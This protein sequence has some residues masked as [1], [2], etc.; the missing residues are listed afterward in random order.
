VVHNLISNAIKFTPAGGRIVV[1][2]IWGLAVARALV[3]AH[4]RS[5]EVSGEP[6]RGTT[7]TVHRAPA[8]GG[9]GGPPRA[10]GHQPH[11]RL[12]SP[13]F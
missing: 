6:G 3:E 13:G 12:S 2:L 1:K 10:A 4:S 5:S 11:G 7:F 9:V 8:D